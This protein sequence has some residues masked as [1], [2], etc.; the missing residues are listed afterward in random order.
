MGD[1]RGQADGGKRRRDP[2]KPRKAEREEVAALRG[3][4]RMQL[5]EYDPAQ[6]AEQV[7]RVGGRQEQRELLGRREQDVGRMA[8]LAHA[9]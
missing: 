1:G 6:C 2:V 8:A 9:L 7:G 4:E 3:H 5:V